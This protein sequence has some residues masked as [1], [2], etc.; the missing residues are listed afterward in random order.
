MLSGALLPQRFWAEALSTAVY[1]RNRCPTKA[2]NTTPYEALMGEKPSVGHLRIFRCTAYRR[3]CKDERQKLDSKTVN[4]MLT[5]EFTDR[6]KTHKLHKSNSFQS[7]LV[8]LLS[9]VRVRK[10]REYYG[11][12]IN[13][14]DCNPEPMTV[15]EALKGSDHERWKEAMNTDEIFQRQQSLVTGR[16]S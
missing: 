14:T 6:R 4:C 16:F 5:C 13:L 12:N 8:S 15:N 3:V 9:V 7:I 1:L 11:V 2:I 10:R